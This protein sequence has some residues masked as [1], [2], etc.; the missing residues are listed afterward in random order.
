M[1]SILKLLHLYTELVITSNIAAIYSS[2]L[3]KLVSSVYY[4]IYY[5][6]PGNGF[7]HKNYNSLTESHTQSI[8]YYRTRKVFSSQKDFQAH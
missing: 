4:Y 6:F 3:Q 5:P 7:E 2:L 1:V 8:A